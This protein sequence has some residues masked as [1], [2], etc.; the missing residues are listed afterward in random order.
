[1]SDTPAVDLEFATLDQIAEEL[2]R[3]F[4]TALLMVESADDDSMLFR[5][6]GNLYTAVGMA[7]Q[8][9]HVKHHSQTEICRGDEDDDE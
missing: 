5:T 1:M 8:F 9:I 3:R 6:R 7:S 2:G 4:R